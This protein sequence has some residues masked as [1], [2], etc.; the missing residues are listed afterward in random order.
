M[1][2]GK[3]NMGR[4]AQHPKELITVAAY[5]AMLIAER[6]WL[7]AIE[8]TSVLEERLRASFGV[9]WPWSYRPVAFA[10][11]RLARAG[12][13][14]ERITYYR[15]RHRSKEERREYRLVE[16]AQ[17]HPCCAFFPTVRPVPPGVG[18]RVQGRDW[19]S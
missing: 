15:G 14:Q 7:S 13:V 3:R 19:R 12:F 9:A 10:L 17:A 16:R 1:I 5:A 6:E 4:V 18:R 2:S 8:A 11:R